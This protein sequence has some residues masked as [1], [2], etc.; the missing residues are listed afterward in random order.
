[1]F[2]L[3]FYSFSAYI[4]L[5]TQSFIITA[6]KKLENAVLKLYLI[7]AIKN[8]KPDKVTDFF[9]KMTP[10]LQNQ[11]EWKEWFRKFFKL[12]LRFTLI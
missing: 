5:F 12:I 9:T 6:V 7:N 2:K 8:N 4:T 3:V 1:M 11:N 10:E